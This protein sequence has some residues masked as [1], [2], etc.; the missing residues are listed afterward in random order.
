MA[1]LLNA[2]PKATEPSSTFTCHFLRRS[3]GRLAT[4]LLLTSAM[5]CMKRCCISCSVTLSSLIRRSTLLTNSTGLTLSLRAW[6][7]T[8]SVWGMMPSTAQ[9]RMMHPSRALMALVTSPPK[10]T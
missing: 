1:Q 5:I 4:I 3:S 8:V 7:M 6:R 9:T 10:S 2:E